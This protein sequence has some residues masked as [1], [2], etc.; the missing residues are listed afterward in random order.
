MKSVNLMDRHGREIYEDDGELFVFVDGERD[1][2]PG[3]V[4]DLEEAEKR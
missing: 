1:Y 4:E 2:D 3:L